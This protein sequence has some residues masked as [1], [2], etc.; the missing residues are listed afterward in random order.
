MHARELI[1]ADRDYAE[2]AEK[3]VSM[4]LVADKVEPP[5]DDFCRRHRVRVSVPVAADGNQADVLP[6]LSSPENPPKP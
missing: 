3:R 6:G 2:H 5:I 1:G 4:V